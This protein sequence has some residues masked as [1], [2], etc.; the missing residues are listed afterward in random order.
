VASESLPQKNAAATEKSARREKKPNDVGYLML[1]EQLDEGWSSIGI[2]CIFRQL[3]RSAGL[4]PSS[5]LGVKANSRLEEGASPAPE[6]AWDTT[7][8]CL[9]D[10]HH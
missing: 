10:G 7:S 9:Y 6:G 5:N 2:S 4:A 8:R 1:A 3:L